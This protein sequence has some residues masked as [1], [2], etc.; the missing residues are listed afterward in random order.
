MNLESVLLRFVLLLALFGAM[1]SC[2]QEPESD[3]PSIIESVSTLSAET[4]SGT[5]QRPPTTTQEPPT[6]MVLLPTV[7]PVS[8]PSDKRE[9]LQSASLVITNGMV[10]DGTGAD[11]IT[12]G[13]V[14]IQGN[15]I[16]AVGQS[17]DFKIPDEAVVID[18]G[19]GT[20]LPGVINSHV[21]RVATAATR[22]HLFLLDGITSV[23]DLGDSLARMQKFEQEGIQSGPAA[24]GFKAGPFVTAPG[25]YPGIIPGNTVNYEIQGED[26]AEIAVRDLH[27][28]GADFIKVT[29][30]PGQFLNEHL[31]VINLQELRSIVTT[32][33][34]N[35]LLVRAHVHNDMLD[36]ALEAGVDVIEHVPMPFYSHEDLESM[37]DDAGVFHM[38]SE[39]EAQMLRLIDQG[40]V[41]VPT[42]ARSTDASH[43]RPRGSACTYSRCSH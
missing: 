24:R 17:T 33:H 42:L 7:R 18:A 39:L 21:H 16:V 26:E 25:G 6:A 28:R 35:D 29:L 23:C 15:R 31:P 40:V 41:L 13:L 3:S 30:E 5:T 43:D 11:P 37:F 10:V 32:A 34:A 14:A 9:E 22:R 19:G 36:M 4:S 1:V 8:E 38:P 20:I 12:D 2:Q 27:A